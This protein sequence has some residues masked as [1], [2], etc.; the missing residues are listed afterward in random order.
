MFV[1]NLPA[2]THRKIHK[3]KIR[4]LYFQL[5]YIYVENMGTT[6]HI[7][8]LRENSSCTPAHYIYQNINPV[9]KLSPADETELNNC[10]PFKL[11]L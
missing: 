8:N 4:P 2:F 7:R 6:T 9:F 10:K 1:N 11:E 5:E 3:N